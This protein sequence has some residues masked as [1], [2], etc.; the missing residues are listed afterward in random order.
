MPI[1]SNEGIPIKPPLPANVPIKD[2]AKLIISNK[3]I[4]LNVTP[5][6]FSCIIG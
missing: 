3:M 5:F 6:L 4:V 1:K 2:A